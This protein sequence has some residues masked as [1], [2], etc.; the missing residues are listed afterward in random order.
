MSF[1]HC[2]I[3]GEVSRGK[4]KNSCLIRKCIIL[5]F[6]NKEKSAFSG[7][8]YRFE[9]ISAKTMI[10]NTLLQRAF[11]KIF[12]SNSTRLK[13]KETKEFRFLHINVASILLLQFFV[14]SISIKWEF[15]FYA[16]LMRYGVVKGYKQDN[17]I[18]LMWRK[19]S[20]FILLP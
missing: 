17:S 2:M 9:C 3:Q 14:A 5:V 13:S 4:L 15:W 11:R 7:C 19:R 18:D 1:F 12:L 10:T 20:T 8:K 6:D 16:S